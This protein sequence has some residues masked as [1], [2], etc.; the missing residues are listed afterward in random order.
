MTAHHSAL[1]STLKSADGLGAAPAPG[2][3]GPSAV[4]GTVDRLHK[5]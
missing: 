1:R 4:D 3:A 5:A 2:A